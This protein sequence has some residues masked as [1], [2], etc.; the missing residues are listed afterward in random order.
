MRARPW[1]PVYPAD[2]R[3]TWTMEDSLRRSGLVGGAVTDFPHKTPNK[4][5]FL[6]AWRPILAAEIAAAAAAAATAAAVA[7]AAAGGGATS[8]A[9]AAAEG[10]QRA[11]GG[12]EVCDWTEREWMPGMPPPQTAAGNASAAWVPSTGVYPNPKFQ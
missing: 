4:K 9:A 11:G 2:V 5:I 10:G 6:C 8:K 7:T 3:D 1:T 12:D